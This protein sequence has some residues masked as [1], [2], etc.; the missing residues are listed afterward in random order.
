MNAA[1]GRARAGLGSTGV[2]PSVGAVIVRDGVIIGAGA[3][4]P[5]GPHAEPQAIA[6][7]RARG[8]DPSGATMYVTLEPCNHTGR[9]GPCT[10]AI[11]EAGLSRVVI[12]VLDPWGSMN[13]RSVELL[14]ERGLSVDV[15]SQGDRCERLHLGFIKATTRG[16][17]EVTLKL[18][19]SLDGRIATAAGESQW[20]TGDA[21]RERVQ[22]M[23][24]EH[25]AVLVG[26]GTVLADDPRLTVR[27]DG[28]RQPV[29]VVLDTHLRIAAGAKLFAHPRR[30]LIVCGE[31]APERELAANVVRVPLGADGRVDPVA[32]LRAVCAAGYHRVLVEGGGTIARALLD[33]GLVDTIAWFVAPVL[34][35]GG[36]P[37]VAGPPIGE[38]GAARRFGAAE[39][40]EFLGDDVLL[41]FRAS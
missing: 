22:G 15:G 35:P 18:A 23:R 37:A 24:A 19:A 8:N 31:G 26:I 17:P 34:V 2:R 6:D 5:D 41:V 10:L 9:T 32:A 27:A 39:A 12:G 1:I 13:G 16:L 21:A 30:P 20:I 38:L 11:L 28:A 7:C 36:L 40:V 14:R 3:T 4:H 29:P 33:A 25:D